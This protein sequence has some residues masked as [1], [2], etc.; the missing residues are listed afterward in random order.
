MRDCVVN[1]G[2]P[3]EQ[4]LPL[5]TENT[6]RILKLEQKGTLERGKLGDVLVLERDSLEVR[7]VWSKGQC[8]VRDGAMVARPGFLGESKREILLVGD[9]SRGNKAE[10]PA[11]AQK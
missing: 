8:M 3:L 4:V 6:S 1:H 2:F 10:E 7:Y 9:E 5:V 11:G